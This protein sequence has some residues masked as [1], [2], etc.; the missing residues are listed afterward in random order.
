MAATR[1]RSPVLAAVLT[2]L[3]ALAPG[4]AKPFP[5]NV[6]AAAAQD[7]AQAGPAAPLRGAATVTNYTSRNWAGYFT[8]NA[9]HTTDFR[10]V[11]AR[12]IQPKIVCPAAKDA[13]VVSWVGMDGWWNDIVEQGGSSARCAN[14][15]PQY[16]LW[17]EMFPHNDIQIANPTKPGDLIDAT[18]TYEPVPKKF[19]IVV[20]D[21]TTGQT[22]VRVQP[23]YPDMGGCPRVNAEAITETPLGGN[24][25]DGVFFLPDYGAVRY[26]HV[27][28]TDTAG[29]VGTLADAHWDLGHVNQVSPSSG[30]RKQTALPLGPNGA[31][32]TT[33]W[34]HE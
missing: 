20:K 13:W 33:V 3:L 2:G 26:D 24:A 22:L 14:G 16:A 34:V 29:H 30:V 1:R 9:A 11:H 19:R 4:A 8:T 10:S 15:V 7:Q 5:A 32:F 28:V 21:L 27:S 12:W 17:W 23:C 25:G 18:V 6:S 31:S